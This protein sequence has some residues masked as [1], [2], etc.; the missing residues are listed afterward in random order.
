MRL[1]LVKAAWDAD[2]QVWFVEASDLPGL[3]VEA[4]TL[5]GLRTQVELAAADLLDKAGEPAP[6][7][8][9]IEIVAHAS[10]RARPATVA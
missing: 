5:E 8:V 4:P 1:I 9:P 2:A 7:D 6:Y 3:N 10:A